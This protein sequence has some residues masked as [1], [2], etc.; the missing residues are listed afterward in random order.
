MRLWKRWQKSR[1]TKGLSGDGMGMERLTYKGTPTMTEDGMITPIYCDY[2]T[3]EIK[4]K[5]ADYEDAEDAGLLLRLPCKEET[6]VWTF[7]R[8]ICRDKKACKDCIYFGDDGLGGCCDYEE[9]YPDCTK[10]YETKFKLDMLEKFGKTVFLTKKEAEHAL[11][12]MKG[13]KE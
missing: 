11:A 8:L 4:S 9:D 13:G 5:L 12:E 3:K 6:P 10:V 7:D 1:N 2:S